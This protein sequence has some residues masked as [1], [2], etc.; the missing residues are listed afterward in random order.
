MSPDELPSDAYLAR[1]WCRCPLLPIEEG[2]DMALD[3]PLQSA[4]PTR[5]RVTLKCSAPGC[6]ITYT[7]VGGT[8]RLKH[9]QADVERDAAAARDAAHEWGWT[10]S[11]GGEDSADY[12]PRHTED[13]DVDHG[14]GY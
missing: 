9:E 3:K 1:A 4:W 7:Y 5:T 12:C 11:G 10:T 2:T 6:G 14:Q 13:D 8:P